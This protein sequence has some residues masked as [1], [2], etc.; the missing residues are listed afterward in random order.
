ML[1]QPLHDA[2]CLQVPFDEPSWFGTHLQTGSLFD[3]LAHFASPNFGWP[4]LHF[5]GGHADVEARAAEVS[6]GAR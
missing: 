6:T 3:F 1:E 4:T 2:F 5:T